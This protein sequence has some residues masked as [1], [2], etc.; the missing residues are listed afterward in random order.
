MLT[1]FRLIHISDIHVG[2]RDPGERD[3]D[4]RKC[5]SNDIAFVHEKLGSKTN[6]IAI[7]GD[8][9]F[10]GTKIQ[11]DEFEQWLSPIRKKLSIPE[12]QI[13]TVPGNHDLDYKKIDDES[14]QIHTEIRSKPWDLDTFLFKNKDQAIES[15][16]LIKKF[17]DYI[18]FANKYSSGF[19]PVQ[20][21]WN[22]K[23]Q[24]LLHQATGEQHK[25]IFHGLNTALLSIPATQEGDMNR[26]AL[27]YR[28]SKLE[29]PDVDISRIALFHHPIMW[30]Y[31][32]PQIK[33]FLQNR[34]R[35][36]LHG[37]E[38]AHDIS[39]VQ[40]GS[41]REYLI[42][43]AGATNPPES[44]KFGSPFVYNWLDLFL[45]EHNEVLYLVIRSYPRIWN[46]RTT[47]FG[48]DR[49]AFSNLVENTDIPY[50]DFRLSIK[51]IGKRPQIVQPTSPSIPINSI[52]W[53]L[54]IEGITHR[55]NS[56]YIQALPLFEKSVSL[57][58]DSEEFDNYL[59]IWCK[60][61]LAEIY[62]FTGKLEESESI[63]IETLELAA[64]TYGKESFEFSRLLQCLAGV[65]HEKAEYT[66]AIELSQKALDIYHLWG[67][68]ES[69]GAAQLLD[70]IAGSMWRMG[71]H[72][73]AMKLY[74]Q[75]EVYWRKHKSMHPVELGKC[76]SEQGKCLGD[77]PNRADSAIL[78]LE[79]AVR[80]LKNT[81]HHASY[82]MALAML[83]ITYGGSGKKS[84]G[85]KLIE[86]ALPLLEASIGPNHKDVI[87]L[88]SL[89][90]K[91][92]S[93]P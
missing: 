34:A 59:K 14:K 10:S 83:G 44:E 36:W 77:L 76:L 45:E 66:K 30:L 58:E 12:N 61:N 3:L 27:G 29:P 78:R 23:E 20:T 86:E 55:K 82:G 70:N 2:Q 73:Q 9:T 52:I 16:S 25:L 38:H 72:D 67:L 41:D 92:N 8:I 40:T 37:H 7:T 60:A 89:L 74:Q 6:S 75:A 90:N 62:Y 28:Q 57:L 80:I 26:L 71:Q 53:K 19:T 13:M 15:H 46:T 42:L 65:A 48:P 79:E 17:T 47:E 84:K 85:K 50:K 88:K 22:S 64:K 51:K 24:T 87:D 32:R 91:I 1:K 49:L 43:A 68:A 21:H 81:G 33:E 56:K 54:M 39:T 4:I 5:I 35:I 63:G 93:R 69:K 31:D 11:Y 18:E